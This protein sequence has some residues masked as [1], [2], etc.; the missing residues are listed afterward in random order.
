[1]KIS[2]DEAIRRQ[3]AVFLGDKDG[4][5]EFWFDARLRS[6]TLAV[7]LMFVLVPAG[8]QLVYVAAAWTSTVW[9]LVAALFVGAGGGAAAAIGVTRWY[10][11]YDRPETRLDYYAQQAWALMWSPKAPGPPVEYEVVMPPPPPAAW[12]VGGTHWV[13]ATPPSLTTK[14]EQEN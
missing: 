3:E 7:G 5:M 1:M 6:Q 12:A 13:A 10:A 11:K 2:D 14:W 8:F 4:R 9:Q